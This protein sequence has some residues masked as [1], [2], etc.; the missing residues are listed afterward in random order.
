MVNSEATRFLLQWYQI[1]LNLLPRPLRPKLTKVDPGC[2]CRNGTNDLLWFPRMKAIHNF[3]RLQ[4]HF[5]EWLKNGTGFLP[6]H[7]LHLS[8]DTITSSQ[9]VSGISRKQC[10]PVVRALALRSG[11]PGFK[12]RSDHSL[13]LILVVPCSTFQLHL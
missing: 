2:N 8:Y 9:W 12:T 13:N 10:G 6:M 1:S 4:P 5:V 11:D 7:S 3:G